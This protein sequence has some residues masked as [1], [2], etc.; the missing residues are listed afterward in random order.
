MASQKDAPRYTPLYP[1]N[2]SVDAGIKEFISAFYQVSDKPG[3]IDEWADF[4]HGDARLVMANR[5]ATGTDGTITPG[6]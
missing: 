1:S 5:V 6:L 3:T 4:F 2:F